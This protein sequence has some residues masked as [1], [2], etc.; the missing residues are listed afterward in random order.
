ML[1]PVRIQPKKQPSQEAVDA[2]REA[3][4]G[5][6]VEDILDLCYSFAQ[7]P[8][9]L[10]V[11]LD[12]LRS[13]G[14]M[15]AQA[16]ACLICFDLARRGNQTFEAEF[17]TLVPVM[18]EY[19]LPEIEPVV[20]DDDLDFMDLVDDTPR[21]KR[22]I[23]D[24]VGDNAFLRGLLSELET[25]LSQLD[26]RRDPA[27]VESFAATTV[28]DVDIVEIELFDDDELDI[29][30]G[31]FDILEEVSSL[32]D[33]WMDALD[34]FIIG[35]APTDKRGKKPVGFFADDK[36]HLAELEKLH[37]AA[38]SL[39]APVDGARQ[40]LPF[41]DLFFASH[42]RAKNL[43]GKRNAERDRYL[44]DGLRR[45]TS[46]EAPPADV[47]SWLSPPTAGD[48]TW[49]KVA[50]LLLDYCAYVGSL[51]D[52]TVQDLTAEQ[53]AHSYVTSS[54]PQPPSPVLQKGRRGR[55]R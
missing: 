36:V 3:A 43:F 47:V 2:L 25:S 39:E 34:T 41:L 37:T 23:D 52:D 24:L 35:P 1:L 29:E 44:K 10:T 15:K 9:R 21:G 32:H 8:V 55:R 27:P 49:E 31:D 40:L 17:L 50:E 6:E 28:E 46:A 54:R 38:V 48:F 30:L 12:A 22:P 20:D 5:L 26:P 42:L 14:S 16:A 7:D 18:Q 19:V 13:K 51:D 45:F 53:L 33:N 11:Y 4:S